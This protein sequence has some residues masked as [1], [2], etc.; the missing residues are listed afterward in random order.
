MLLLRRHH[1]HPHP[2]ADDPGDRGRQLL[3]RP[4]R[5]RTLG[6]P[7]TGARRCQDLLLE[8]PQLTRCVN[9]EA[10]RSG[11][12]PPRLEGRSRFQRGLGVC[13]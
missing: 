7:K 6:A 13:E 8:P 2:E 5:A 11:A 3:E 4:L 12:V 10:R 1:L 9:S